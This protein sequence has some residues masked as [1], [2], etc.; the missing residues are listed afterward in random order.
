MKLCKTL[1][2]VCWVPGLLGAAAEAPAQEKWYASISFGASNATIDEGVV[3]VTGT[4]SSN[5]SRDERD[6]GFKVLVGY[7]FSPHFALEG[8]YAHL[9]EF[10]LTRD[11][12]APTAGTVNADVRIKGLVL[13]VVGT[14]P[15]GRGISGFAKLGALLSET[16]TFRV[17]G[18]TVA[19]PFG[20]GSTINDELNLKFGLGLQ[21]EVSSRVSLRGELERYRKV[22][23]ATTTGEVSIDLYS[24]GLLFRF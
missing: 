4:T 8:G 20:S 6:P 5:V 1:V 9:G 12:S 24:V 11:V 15:I 16:K 10:R 7:Q 3:A 22:G 23:E 21:Y 19:T 13:D 18:G 2:I 17:T 14:L